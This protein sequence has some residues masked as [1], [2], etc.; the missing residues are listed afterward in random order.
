VLGSIIDSDSHGRRA[1]L[2][3]QVSSY[4]EYIAAILLAEDRHDHHLLRRN[5]RRKPQPSVIAVRH[6]ETAT[7]RVVAPHDVAY[8]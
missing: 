1:Q 5:A 7:S 6:H 2:T 8:G 4:P 3:G